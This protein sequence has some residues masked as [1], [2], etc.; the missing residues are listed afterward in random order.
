MNGRPFGAESRRPVFNLVKH[1][2][3]S[4][5]SSPRRPIRHARPEPHGYHRPPFNPHNSWGQ[6][7]PSNAFS[8]PGALPKR[9]LYTEYVMKRTYRTVSNRMSPR[10][11]DGAQ[12]Q[13]RKRCAGSTLQWAVQFTLV[14]HRPG[15]NGERIPDA[16]P[17]GLCSPRRWRSTDSAARLR[18]Q[19]KVCTIPLPEQLDLKGTL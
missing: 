2:P 9:L 19:Q 4:S 10:F 15:S 17:D 7:N 8:S 16:K 18:E 12:F 6:I 3:T 1:V 11:D 14:D 5:Y 13:T